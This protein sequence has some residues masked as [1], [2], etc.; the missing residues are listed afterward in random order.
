[1]SDKLEG[2]IRQFIDLLYPPDSKLPEAYFSLWEMPGKASYHYRLSD[3]ELEIAAHLLDREGHNV[4]YG[5]GLRRADLGKHQRGSKPDI[6]ALPGFWADIDIKGIN[7]S[8]DNLPGN[9]VDVVNGILKPFAWEPSAVVN[10]GGGIHAYWLFDKPLVITDENRAEVEELSRNFQ[11]SL[12]LGARA[13]GWKWDM[14]ADLPRVL[15]PVGTHNRKRDEPVLVEFMVPPTGT[16]YPYSLF[17]KALKTKAGGI[18]SMLGRESTTPPPAEGPVRLIDER[19]EEDI[20]S[21]LR[22]KMRKNR[23]VERKETLQQILEGEPFAV[24][25][26]RDRK[27]QQVCSWIAWY[28]QVADPEILVDILR[29]SLDVMA[30]AQ[31]E[32]AM[33]VEDAIEKIARAQNDARRK[34]ALNAATDEKIKEVLRQDSRGNHVRIAK[35]AE[36]VAVPGPPSPNAKPSGGALPLDVLLGGD[37]KPRAQAALSLV[38]NLA[39][40]SDSAPTPAA[41]GRYSFD[42]IRSFMARQE[43][44]SGIKI[45]PEAWKKRWVIRYGDAIFIFRNGRYLSAIQTKNFRT[46]AGRDL[47]CLLPEFDEEGHYYF[48]SLTIK[49]DGTGMRM[50]E[51]E[52]IFD[53]I[54]HVARKLAADTSLVDSYYDPSSETFYEAVCPLRRDLE[55]RY[56]PNIQKWLEL[57]GGADVEKLLDWIATVTNLEAPSCGLFLSGPPNTGKSMLANGLAHLWRAGGYTRMEDIVGSFNDDLAQCPLVVA[58]ETLPDING[59]PLSTKRLRDFISQDS[60][61]L[62]RKFVGNVPFTGTL[63]CMFL[64][65]SEDMLDLGDETLGADSLAAVAS[66]FLHIVTT[67]E[68]SEFITSL[69]GRHGGTKDWVNGDLIARHA[70]WLRDTRKVEP[71]GRFWVQGHVSKMHRLLATA[72]NL[73]GTTAEWIVRALT[74]TK[75]AIKAIH[76]IV[77]GNG[78]LWVRIEAISEYWQDYI[79]SRA[80][81]PSVQLLKKAMKGIA[82]GDAVRLRPVKGKRFNYWPINVDFLLAWARDHGVADPDEL[83]DL[84]NEKAEGLEVD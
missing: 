17:Q 57:L 74:F 43:K 76:G 63:R 27:L 51:N 26:E 13:N 41:D 7:H 69:G 42:E 48:S 65:N 40:A 82:L 49:P 39:G 60:R 28:D 10:S 34:S 37:S 71:D 73:G 8:A 32:G 70:L 3:P 54:A 35:P 6:V 52:Q 31:P 29:P 47:Y 2:S 5:V 55:P 11:E 21:D 80:N 22:T 78:Q 67:K 1:M 61:S 83:R 18:A 23:K 56:D 45:T 64:A 84:I 38:Q 36:L 14:T 25:G 58:D 72:S 50:K 44:L 66:R 30:A 16:R 33:T 59:K 68:S 75:P 81:P 15:R 20:L 4:F 24:V 53:E 79:R 9:I 46:S 77:C 19:K 62:K 12:A